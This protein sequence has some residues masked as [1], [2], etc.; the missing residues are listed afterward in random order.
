MGDDAAIA[1]LA[2]RAR[3][4]PG[5]FKQRFAQVSN[6]PIDHLRERVIFSLRTLLGERAPILT[7]GPEA[8]KLIELESFFLFPSALDELETV[9]L[10]ATFDEKE[11]LRAACKRLGERA[12]ALAE[13]GSPLLLVSDC[14]ISAEISPLMRT[15]VAA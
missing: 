10:D 5:F 3:L 7:E 4:L 15:P 2:N 11:G 14:S 8:A 9:R 13:E 1:P 12:T 6:P